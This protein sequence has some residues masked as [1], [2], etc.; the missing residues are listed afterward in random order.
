MNENTSGRPWLIS[1]VNINAP[2][3][4]LCFSI[5]KN[6]DSIPRI[7]SVLPGSLL[8]ECMDT[9]S[10]VGGLGRGEGDTECFPDTVEV[11]KQSC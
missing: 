7:L 6:L 2:A 3:I 11:R 8:R 5:T 4:M 1:M 9:L 10:R